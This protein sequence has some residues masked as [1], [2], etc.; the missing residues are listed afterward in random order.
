MYS[1]RG[2]YII[3]NDKHVI[4]VLSVV[5]CINPVPICI[6]G[7]VSIVFNSLFFRLIYKQQTET[8]VQEKVNVTT[9][10]MHASLN[11]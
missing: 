10:Q 2:E 9:L 6:I 7:W 11:L 5:T 3:N 4:I 1:A 8:C